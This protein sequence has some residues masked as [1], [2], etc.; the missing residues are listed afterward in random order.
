MRSRRYYKRRVAKRFI[1]DLLN[2]L[3]ENESDQSSF[4]SVFCTFSY[5]SNCDDA[6]NCDGTVCQWSLSD[7][8]EIYM[9]NKDRFIYSLVGTFRVLFELHL[10]A[11]AQARNYSVPGYW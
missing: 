5:C 6:G 4:L 3:S 11:Q 9:K 8:V 7:M 2:L 10:K 1:K